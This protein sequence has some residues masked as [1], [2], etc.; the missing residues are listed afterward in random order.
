MSN[1]EPLFHPVVKLPKVYDVY[2]FSQGY[3]P[4]RER[5]IYGIGKYGEKRKGMYVAPRF[6]SSLTKS[7]RNIHL[8]IDI[9]A[10]VGEPVFAFLSGHIVC[11]YDHCDEGNYGPTII[12]KHLLNEKHVWALHGHLSRS[13]LKIWEEGDHFSAGDTLGFIGE[14]NENG[15]WNPHLHFQ[16]SLIAPTHCDYPGVCSEDSWPQANQDFPDPRTILGPLY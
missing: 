1:H 4:D 12:T 5:R 13:S 8:G 3:N 10:P 6:N 11:Q 14:K 15:G 2:D 7:E 9:A 16:I